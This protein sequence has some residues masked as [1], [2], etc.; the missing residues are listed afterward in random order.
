MTG[1]P[2]ELRAATTRRNTSTLPELINY[3]WFS[4][5]S[6]ICL[7]HQGKA[8]TDRCSRRTVDVHGHC[9]S[10][11]T[12]TGDEAPSVANIIV[13]SS[14]L[15]SIMRFAGVH[16]VKTEDPSSCPWR[17][18]YCAAGMPAVL[19]AFR[20]GSVRSACWGG[21]QGRYARAGFLRRWEMFPRTPF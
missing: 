20:L 5:Q 12:R 3:Y 13:R 16:D 19:S 10:L 11:Y 15:E 1:R 8:F 18:S 4:L 6:S 7:A 2:T 17:L 21:T 14:K 9:V